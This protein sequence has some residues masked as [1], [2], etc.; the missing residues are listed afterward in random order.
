V[1]FVA[2]LFILIRLPMNDNAVTNN[3]LTHIALL[4]ILDKYSNLGNATR[5]FISKI[6]FLG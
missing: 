4:L 6:L 3:G 1:K 2:Q 5:K